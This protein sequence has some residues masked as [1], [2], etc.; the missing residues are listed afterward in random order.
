MD[1]LPQ[2]I[3]EFLELYTKYIN[4]EI[5]TMKTNDLE[6][7]EVFYDNLFIS[8][9]KVPSDLQR[10]DKLCENTVPLITKLLLVHR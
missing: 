8:I 2:N 6:S 1:T 3:N 4:S 5:T 9:Q 7:I 10:I